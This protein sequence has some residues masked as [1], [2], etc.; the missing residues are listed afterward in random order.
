MWRSYESEA[1]P[2]VE[3]SAPGRPRVINSVTLDGVMQMGEW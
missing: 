2:A 3:G 1:A